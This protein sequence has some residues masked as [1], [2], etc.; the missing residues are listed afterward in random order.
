VEAEPKVP[1]R[2]GHRVLIPPF[3]RF[4]LAIFAVL[5]LVNVTNKTIHGWSFVLGPLGAGL[6]VLI[7]RWA[8]LSAGDLGLGRGTYRSGLMFAAVEIGLIFLVFAAA[9]AIPATRSA[10]LDDRNDRGIPQAIGAALFVIPL[11]TVLFEEFAFRGVLWGL[12]HRGHTAAYATLWSSLLFG[13]WHVLPALN[14]AESNKA[15]SDNIALSAGISLVVVAANVIFT[16]LAG[17][18]LCELRR[19]S[20]SLIAPIALHWATNGLGVLF[21]AVLW[22]VTGK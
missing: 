13:V 18:V 8:R 12:L 20:G 6:L 21:A 17:V 10:F 5:V 7:A 4:V 15:V 3:D 1:S 16:G 22:S 14:F 11:G 2:R 19:R 9:A